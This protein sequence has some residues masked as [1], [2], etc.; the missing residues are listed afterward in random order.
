MYKREV[1][2][3]N[4]ALISLVASSVLMAG[5]Y[6]IP[7][8]STN[9]VALSAANV[10]HNHNSADAAYYNPA[11]MIFMSDENHI[12]SNL[13]YIGLDETKYKGD[14]SFLGT[15][16]GSQN[17]KSEKENFLVPSIH[18]VS[19][20]LGK[21]SARVGLSVFS[22]GGLT[23]RWENSV[24]SMGAEEF[25]MQT[26]EI[27]PT[28]AFEVSKKLGV[29]F[30]F[31]AVHS[32]GVAKA[33]PAANAVYQDMEGDSLDFGYNLALAYQP[34]EALE[35]GVTYRSKIDLVLD[36]KADL[37]YTDAES[38]A[39]RLD[40]NYDGSV[41]LPLPASLNLAVA[42][43][44]PTKTT[45]EFVYERTMWSAYNKLDF[46]YINP[47]AEFIFGNPKEKN[48]KNTNSYRLGIT[49]E[50]DTV[51]LMGGAV[52]DKSPIPEKTL[53]FELPDS[54]SYALSLGVRYQV[55][56]KMN[57]GFSGLYS[58]HKERS[59]DN[60]DLDGTFSGSNVLLLSAGLGYKF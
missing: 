42:Y 9:A 27:N 60:D 26:I 30:G 35:I 54:N 20:K 10:A 5:G 22:P 24:A 58:I 11:K 59:V 43:T 25:S 15:P 56:E 51:T 18:Y 21:N 17:I 55:N 4:I 41:T 52:I 32:S 36:G 46:K 7:E 47:V 40:G 23:K 14:V 34:S 37:K 8:N 38:G 3:K 29:A 19:S 1:K 53:G 31:R 44:M 12:D 33:T 57:I 50:L 13:I 39:V 49:Q 2:M 16:L 48:W 28:V 6:K 45:V